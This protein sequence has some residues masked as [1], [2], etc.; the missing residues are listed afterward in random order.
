MAILKMYISK[1]KLPPK[2]CYESYPDDKCSCLLFLYCHKYFWVNDT[3]F[4]QLPEL[5]LGGVCFEQPYREMYIC[6]LCISIGN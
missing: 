3:I 1:Y 6:S 4:C 5:I 2:I